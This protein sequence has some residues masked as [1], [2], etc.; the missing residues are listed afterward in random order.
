LPQLEDE[1]DHRDVAISYVDLE[2][3]GAKV[4]VRGRPRLAARRLNRRGMRGARTDR[5]GRSRR[6]PKDRRSTRAPSGRVR[7]ARP[8]SRSGYAVSREPH[9]RSRRRCAQHLVSPRPRSRS[10]PAGCRCSAAARCSSRGRRCPRGNRGAPRST[11]MGERRARCARSPMRA[12]RRRGAYWYAVAWKS[13]STPWI[14][15]CSRTRLAGPPWF[16]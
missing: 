10:V 11:R 3:I 13:W 16:L 4:N 14:T 6:S 1:G 12:P 7:S 9:G 15:A 5:R 8:A 2:V